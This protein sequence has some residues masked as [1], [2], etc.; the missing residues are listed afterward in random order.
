MIKTIMSNNLIFISVFTLLIYCILKVIYLTYLLFKK[1]FKRKRRSEN[2]EA[3]KL[4]KSYADE[5]KFYNS[6]NSED[7]KKYF[8]LSKEDKIKQYFS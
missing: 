5:L 4:I 8:K 3:I 1:Y 6:L 7:Q 2:F